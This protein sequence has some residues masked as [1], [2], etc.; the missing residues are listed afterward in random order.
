MQARVCVCVGHTTGQKADVRGGVPGV[1]SLGTKGGDQ[2]LLMSFAVTETPSDLQVDRGL[3][4][5]T[6][7][8]VTVPVARGRPF[9][10]HKG[11]L[12]S[13]LHV[14]LLAS[15]ASGEGATPT[16]QSRR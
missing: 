3:R 9:P 5:L 15:G 13:R 12:L 2:H 14:L 7:L 10:V 16:A 8:T 11:D 1:R 4:F 6:V